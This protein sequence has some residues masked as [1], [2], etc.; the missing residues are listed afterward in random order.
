[1]AKYGYILIPAIDDR[2]AFRILIN[3]YALSA[4]RA[5]VKVITPE[6]ALLSLSDHYH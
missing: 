2:L 6:A 1:M 4:F 5:Y 3:M